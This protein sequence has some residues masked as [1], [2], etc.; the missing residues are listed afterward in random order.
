MSLNF[1]VK[2]FSPYLRILQANIK[3]IKALLTV[4]SAAPVLSLSAIIGG[5][6]GAFAF[7]V[8]ISTAGF[9]VTQKLRKQTMLRL[10]L[11]ALRNAKAGH[12]ATGRFIPLKLHKQYTAEKVLGKGAYGCV[13]LAKKIKGGQRVAIKLIVPEKGTFD[14]REL[15]QLHRESSVLELFTASK[16]EHAVNLA[17]IEAVCI[18]Q[19]LAWFIMEVVVHDQERGP[20]ADVE[21]IKVSRNILAALKVAC[22][23]LSS[24]L[25]AALKRLGRGLGDAFRRC[26]PS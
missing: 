9:F 4:T 23:A 14:D 17:G 19:D 15:R 11:A 10:F 20:I 21:C 5:C 13:V 26:G 18:S 6:V 12:P 7:T 24:F 22:H 25:Q 16:C 3:S 2:N 1:N 8:L